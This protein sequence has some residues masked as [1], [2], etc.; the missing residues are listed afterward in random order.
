MNPRKDTALTPLRRMDGEPVFD[1]PWQAQALAMADTL[2]ARGV[3]SAAEWSDTLG[4]ELKDAEERDEPD[5]PE[6]YYNAVLR[7]LEALL[8]RSGAIGADA[9]EARREAWRQAY[10]STPHG[11]PVELASEGAM[12]AESAVDEN[13]T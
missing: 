6:T 3:F 10:L 12:R 9:M 7:A 4:A 8:D 13:A 1:E 5:R 2:V 11:Q